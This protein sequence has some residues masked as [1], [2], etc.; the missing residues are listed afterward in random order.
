MLKKWENLESVQEGN[1][2][3]IFLFKL[4]ESSLDFK[5]DAS[6]HS[7]PRTRVYVA[8][9]DLQAIIKKKQHSSDKT[10]KQML[11]KNETLS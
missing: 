3:L 6:L 8:Q 1:V 11:N 10:Q 7:E 2:I 5:G 4:C 9:I